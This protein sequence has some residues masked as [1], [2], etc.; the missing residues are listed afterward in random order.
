MPLVTLPWRW[1]GE[2]ETSQGGKCVC[3]SHRSPDASWPL[4]DMRHGSITITRF[5]GRSS[6]SIETPSGA[7][8]GIAGK[9][10]VPT[11][12]RPSVIRLAMPH[13]PATSVHAQ[14]LLLPPSLPLLPPQSGGGRSGCGVAAA[15]AA[16]GCLLLPTSP[17]RPARLPGGR[18][19][20]SPSS[21]AQH[22][23]QAPPRPGL[24]CGRR[25]RRRHRSDRRRRRSDRPGHQSDR[26][27]PADSRSR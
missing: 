22:L 12:L 6:N 18:P 2:V 24:T 16:L 7:A 14:L 8:K 20:R 15:G 9:A 10:E 13:D 21:C 5:M 1:R 19:H 3:I 17:A 23:Q 27:G 11:P 26:P 4:Q 25:R